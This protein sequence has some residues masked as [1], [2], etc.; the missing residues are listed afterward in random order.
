MNNTKN[1][2]CRLCAELKPHNELANLQTD[3]ET[4]QKVVNKLS[5]FNIIMDFQDNDLPRTV[6]LLCVNSLEQAFSFVTAIEQAQLFLSDYIL[7]QARTEKSDVCGEFDFYIPSNIGDTTDI[8]IESRRD[9]VGISNDSNFGEECED[10]EDSIDGEEGYNESKNLTK[11]FVF[12][13]DKINIKDETDECNVNNHK[14]KTLTFSNDSLEY[15]YANE[16]KTVLN[17]ETSKLEEIVT[18]VKHNC[19]PKP[20]SGGTGSGDHKSKLNHRTVR[21]VVPHTRKKSTGQSIPAKHL[22]TTVYSEDY[23]TKQIN[24]LS[25]IPVECLKM[26]W[27]DYEWKCSHC[28]TLFSNIEELQ[29]H[30]ML[31][32]TTCNA[33]QCTDCKIKK[34]RLNAFIKHVRSHRK[35]LHYSCYKCFEKFPKMMET[36]QHKM[37]IHENSRFVCLGCNTPFASN[38][39]MEEHVNKYYNIL[40]RQKTFIDSDNLTC[41]TCN[42]VC[43]NVTALRNHLNRHKEKKRDRVCDRCGKCFDSAPSLRTHMDTH[44]EKVLYHCEICKTTFKTIYSLRYHASIHSGI[45]PFTCDVCN[46]C[47]RTR[48]QITNHMKFHT[49]YFPIT[50]TVCNKKFRTE[51]NLQNHMLQHTGEKPFSC[52]ICLRDFTNMANRNKHM[53]RRHG[54]EMSKR[55]QPIIKQQTT[56]DPM[57]FNLVPEGNKPADLSSMDDWNHKMISE[58]CQ[59][60]N[61]KSKKERMISKECNEN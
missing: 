43:A 40:W 36:R 53:R 30:S 17:T 31:Y 3:E 16:S 12:V 29:K 48:S 1:V 7:V 21:A 4:C 38:A 22:D 28:G 55:R 10:R 60:V 33:Y 51:K 5:R 15:Q 47:F 46:K 49:D 18:N 41:S 34:H 13:D 42:K 11:S 37:K 58:K 27:M 20:L 19:D 45:K 50:C 26:T 24:K 32:H 9:P 23:I 35:Y 6:C 59:R 14:D 2:Y 52:D 61:N 56:D 8:K 25:T 39:E 57:A 44:T 54:I